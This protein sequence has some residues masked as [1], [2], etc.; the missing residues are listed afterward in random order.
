MIKLKDLLSE[1][2]WKAKGKYLYAPTGEMTSIP[3]IKDR[4]AVLI[5]TGFRDNWHIYMHHSKPGMI[6]LY[7]GKTD[8]F[9]KNANDLV[10]WLNKNY[11]SYVGIDNR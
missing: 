2:K 9:F 8:K 3:G 11:A 7:N 10:K 1:G 5:D 4:D 6:R